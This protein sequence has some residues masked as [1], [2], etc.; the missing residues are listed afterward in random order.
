MEATAKLCHVR[1]S[2]RKVGVVGALIRGKD[3]APAKAI[4][5]HTPK[6]GARHLAKL[7]DSA[8][9]NAENNLDMN[10]DTLYVSRVLVGAGPTMKRV[11]PRAKGRANRIAKR[12]SH[13]TLT[14][15]NRGGG[16]EDTA[17]S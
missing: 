13:I 2:P 16:A 4:L 14:V 3:V 15:A 11:M 7:L 12:T 5:L 9:A 17:E 6:A 10:R 1:I 8:C